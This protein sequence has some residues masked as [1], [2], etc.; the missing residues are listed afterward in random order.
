MKKQFWIAPVVGLLLVLM[1][2]IVV[3]AIDGTA[4]DWWVVAGGGA[5]SNTDSI[6]MNGT[7]GQPVVGLSSGGNVSLSAGY[8]AAGAEYLIN[9]PLIY[10]NH[11]P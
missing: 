1:S 2:A 10:Y 3:L 9:F 4:V 7:L 11:T 5:P 8:W 6:T